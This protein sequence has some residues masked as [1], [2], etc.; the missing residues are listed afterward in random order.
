L[1]STHVVMC[2]CESLTF[3]GG[4]TA[5]SLLG[6]CMS[7]RSLQRAVHTAALNA[8]SINPYQKSPK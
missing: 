2:A 3:E 6:P 1:D 5:D 4:I 7:Y 8:E